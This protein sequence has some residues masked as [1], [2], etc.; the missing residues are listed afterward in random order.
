MSGT[1]DL[2]VA[3]DHLCV[4]FDPNRETLSLLLEAAEQPPQTP[5][6]APEIAVYVGGRVRMV[7]R[8]ALVDV[9]VDLSG[10]LTARNA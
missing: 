10:D 6:G 5:D 3:G 4:G 7:L 2:A 9:P 1:D 8:G